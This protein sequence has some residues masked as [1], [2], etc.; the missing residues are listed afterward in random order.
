M[1]K[2][3]GTLNNLEAGGSYDLLMTAFPSNTYP[4][5]RLSFEFTNTPRKITGV[6]KV[7]QCFTYILLTNKGSDPVKPEFGTR[8]SEYII[9]GNRDG[10]LD[11]LYQDVYVH[12]NDAAAQTKAAL[13]STKGDLSSQ[14]SS[15]R[16]LSVTGQDDA[17][18]LTIQLVTRNGET[19]AVAIPFPQ[20]DLGT[21][22]G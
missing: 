20:L 7:A 6:Q 5:G 17:V 2:R 22:N 21:S 8:L 11:K 18:T 14:L 9:T 3:V 13:N 4:E 15:V 12:V 10:D 19:A 16:L 1:A